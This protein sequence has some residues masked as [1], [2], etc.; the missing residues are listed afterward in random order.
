[1][2]LGDYLRNRCGITV[3]WFVRDSVIEPATL[4]AVEGK[5][6]RDALV[7]DRFFLN[8]CTYGYSLNWWKWPE[9]ERFIDWLALNGVNMV[10]ANTGQEAVWQKVWMQFGLSAEQTRAYFTGPSYLAWHRMSNI[11]NWDGPLPQSWIDAQ[12]ELQKQ[13]EEK[14][15]L[16]C[17]NPTEETGCRDYDVCTWY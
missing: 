10:L 4:P 16:V 8:Y 6:H 14:E 11:D 15:K 9:W 1:M 12:A 7:R 3:T 2:G 5:V 13:I 17:S